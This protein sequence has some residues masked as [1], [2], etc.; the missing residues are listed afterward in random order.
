M[1]HVGGGD[2]RTTHVPFGKSGK[3]APILRSTLR[4]AQSENRAVFEDGSL[5]KPGSGTKRPLPK[6]RRSR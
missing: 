4:R 1:K 3:T 5:G 6:G 2:P